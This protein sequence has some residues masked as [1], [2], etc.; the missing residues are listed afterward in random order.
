MRVLTKKNGDFLSNFD[1]S[2]ED[3]INDTTL[4]EKLIDNHTKEKKQWK[5][6]SAN[7][8]GINFW[9]L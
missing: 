7:T 1:K 6:I 4:K 8:F 3:N 9:I 2:F 5:K